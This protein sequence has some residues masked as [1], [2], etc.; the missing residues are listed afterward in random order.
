M[1]RQPLLILF[2]EVQGGAVRQCIALGAGAAVVLTGKL[3]PGNADGRVIP[4]QTALVTGMV[5]I[6]HLIAE[7]CHI[8][9]YQKTMSKAF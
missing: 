5:E 4:G 7:F 9:Q 3:R 8:R 6:R 2:A 1:N